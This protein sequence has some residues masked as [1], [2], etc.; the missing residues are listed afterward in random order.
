MSYAEHDN[1]SA[2]AATPRIAVDFV[3]FPFEVYPFNLVLGDPPWSFSVIEDKRRLWGNQHPYC[4]TASVTVSRVSDGGN[5]IITNRYTDT[6]GSGVPNF[7]SW[8]VEGWEYDTL[9]VELFVP[10]FY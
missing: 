1:S 6:R 2:T 10:G 8:Q 5:L 4:E 3:A 7:L 9:Y